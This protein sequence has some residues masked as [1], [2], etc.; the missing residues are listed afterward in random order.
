MKGSTVAGGR[1]AGACCGIAYACGLPRRQSGWRKSSAHLCVAGCCGAK[2]TKLAPAGGPRAYGL[3]EGSIEPGREISRP[4][5]AKTLPILWRIWWR[6]SG[7][8]KR[9]HKRCS[10]KRVMTVSERKTHRSS[11]P[12][13]GTRKV[14]TDAQRTLVTR[15]AI[16]RETQCRSTQRAENQVQFSARCCCELAAYHRHDVLWGFVLP[17]PASRYP[18]P[19]GPRGPRRN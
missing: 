7:P 13:T 15:L 6:M 17:T 18:P 19:P 3:N 11:K 5:R 16:G 2:G 12:Q 14:L 4:C 9:R 1:C 10:R 8:H